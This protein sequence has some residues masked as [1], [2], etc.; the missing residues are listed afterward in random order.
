MSVSYGFYNS[1]NH[2]RRY[3]ANEMASIFDGLISDGVYKS[4]GDHL[5]VTQHGSGD[6]M[7]VDVGSGRAWFDHTWIYNNATL[8]LELSPSNLVLNR[9][10]AVVIEV[11]A[12][13]N[14]RENSIKVVTGTPSSNPVRPT[15]IDDADVHQY[16]LAYIYVSAA[17]ES[18]TNRDI[19]DVIGTD[20]TPF[21]IGIVDMSATIA[22]AIYPVGS[23]YMSTVNVNPSTYFAGTT[24]VPWGSGKVPVGV[25]TSD[26]DFN[27]SEKSGGTKTKTFRPS[28]TV[29][30][31]TFTGSQSTLSHTGGSVGNHKLTI[32]EIPSH[33]H[34]VSG[35]YRYE[36]VPVFKKGAVIYN[37][38]P[39]GGGGSYVGEFA[40]STSDIA[41]VSVTSY[42]GDTGN[43]NHPFTN[44]NAHTYTPS[45]SVSQPSFIGDDITRSVVQPYITCYMW[46]R[47]A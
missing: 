47:T 37:V 17:A 22:N 18:I 11:N 33:S 29:S 9:I 35:D 46:K 36:A 27:I 14:V 13:V 28:G 3:S 45:G 16:A 5:A 1:L 42:T 38:W 8:T 19:T 40:G 21:V 43:H 15:L 25:D 41:T 30:K 34:K 23:I 39:A 6:S 26:T 24:W 2:D 12:D 7:S 31:P 20:Q 10:D 4:V 32:D 44:P